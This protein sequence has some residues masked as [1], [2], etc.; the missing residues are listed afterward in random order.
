[1]SEVTSGV[2]VHMRHIRAQKLCA[3]GTKAWFEHHGIDWRRLR[4][5]IPVEEI[6]ATGDQMALDVGK[7]A[8]EDQA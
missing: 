5:G 8:R 4:E 7:R 3:G 2:L 6:E 1:M